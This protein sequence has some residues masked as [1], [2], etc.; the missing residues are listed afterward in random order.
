MITTVYMV[1]RLHLSLRSRRAWHEQLEK[2]WSLDRDSCSRIEKKRPKHL[3]LS[4]DKDFISAQ[5]WSPEWSVF[6]LVKCVNDWRHVQWRKKKKICWNSRRLLWP[7]WQIHFGR[8][9]F[10]HIPDLNSK[11][12]RNRSEDCCTPGPPPSLCPDTNPT[13]FTR[14]FFSLPGSK[15]IYLGLLSEYEMITLTQS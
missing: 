6:W 9:Q 8:R 2:L 7:I 14:G 12:L 1:P 13:L 4:K 10:A 3:Q 15:R 11:I 5:R